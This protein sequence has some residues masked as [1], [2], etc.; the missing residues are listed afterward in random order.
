MSNNDWQRIDDLFHAALA[1]TGESRR[2]FLDEACAGDDA[3]RLAVDRLVRAHDAA[4]GFMSIPAAGQ[5]LGLL[6]EPEAAADGVMV[7]PYR[8]AREIGRGGTGAVYLA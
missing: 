3:L 5:A 1:R 7:G 6:S 8:I 2:V 4:S